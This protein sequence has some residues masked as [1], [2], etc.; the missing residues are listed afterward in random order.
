[1][2]RSSLIA[3]RPSCG[4]GAAVKG[5]RAKRAAEGAL[6]SRALRPRKMP[7]LRS[8]TDVTA[9]LGFHRHLDLVGDDLLQRGV[10]GLGE[11]TI[12]GEEL[13]EGL[14]AVDVAFLL[15]HPSISCRRLRAPSI[16]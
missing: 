3:R 1:M 2:Q 15:F 5:P 6:D 10:L 13:I 9:A 12:L 11:Q 7:A 16:A 4:R 14:V 8:R